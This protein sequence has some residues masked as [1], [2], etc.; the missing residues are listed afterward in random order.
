MFNTKD[1]DTNT[2]DTG[3]NVEPVPPSENDATKIE[4]DIKNEYET[5][6]GSTEQS[7]D[8]IDRQK[9]TMADEVPDNTVDEEVVKEDKSPKHSAKPLKGEAGRLTNPTW[10]LYNIVALV[11][12]IL[13]C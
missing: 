7:G 11:N 6:D 4:D 8:E 12:V 5:V 3:G 9:P 2:L 13:L 10:I 1:F